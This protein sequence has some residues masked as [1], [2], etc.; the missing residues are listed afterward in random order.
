[1]YDTTANLTIV[2]WNDNSVVT[3]ASN[4]FSV[5]PLHNAKRYNRKEKKHIHIPQPHMIS[6][7]DKFMG[8]VDQQDN[9]VVNYRINIRGKKWWWWPL[10]VN[11]IDSVIVNAWKLF[12]HSHNTKIPQ[13]D[14]RSHTAVSLMKTFKPSKRNLLMLTIATK[15]SNILSSTFKI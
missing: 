4:N 1:M 5:L 6:E 10:F 8:G 3:M 14:F 2:R 15:E 7:Y 12:Q 11:V 13:L 9:G